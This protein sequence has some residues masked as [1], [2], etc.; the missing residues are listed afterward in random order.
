VRDGALEDGLG[1]GL[2]S[3]IVSEKPPTEGKSRLGRLGAH[4]TVALALT[5]C[6]CI[7]D[8]GFCPPPTVFCGI[9]LIG[10]VVPI[11]P[12]QAAM[13]AKRPNTIYLLRRRKKRIPASFE[14]KQTKTLMRE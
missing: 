2:C 12:W 11:L 14:N 6:A 3:A 4:V 9:G 13:R 8:C 1:D 7:A 5:V 10:G